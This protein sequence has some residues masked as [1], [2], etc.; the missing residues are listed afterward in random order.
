M[1]IVVLHMNIM[2]EYHV[3]IHYMYEYHVVIH[4]MHEYHMVNFKRM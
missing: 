1:N 4:Y 2:Y 3:V